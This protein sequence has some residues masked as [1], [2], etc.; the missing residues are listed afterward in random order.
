MGAPCESTRVL[1]TPDLVI[2]ITK[3]MTAV[4]MEILENFACPLLV[5]DATDAA[6]WASV[7]PRAATPQLML[8][9]M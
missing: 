7:Q 2:S 3:S 4:V 9:G 6:I 1:S 5:D 8:V